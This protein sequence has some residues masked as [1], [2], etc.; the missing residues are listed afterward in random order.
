MIS[1]F[2]TKDEAYWSQLASS[3]VDKIID[4]EYQLLEI[5]GHGAYGCLFLGQSLKDN[6][7]VAVKILA[8]SAELQPLQQLE[9]DIQSELKHPHL[10]AL[11]RFIQDQDYL[12]MI[13]ELCDQGD[14]FDF[15]IKDQ[16]INFVREEGLVK[17]WFHQILDAVEHMHSQGIYHRD[18]K[19]E[20]ILLK[21]QDEDEDELYCKVAD[22]GLA[23]RE[24]YSMEF[25]CG[26]T[27]YLAPEHFDD[28]TDLVPYDAAASDAWSLGILLLAILF[29]R[30][31]WQE[32]SHMDPAYHQFTRNPAMLKDDLFPE[33]SLATL[34]W[35][36]SALTP[37][38]SDR[39][40]VSVLKEQFLA[41]DH[42]YITEQDHHQHTLVD[43]SIP[44]GPKQ[45]NMNSF[46]SAF[47]SGGMSWSDMVEEEEETSQPTKIF[48]LDHPNTIHEDTDIFVHSGE[49]WWL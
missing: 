39:P 33:L 29:G 9:M 45:S 32:A 22:F 5:L 6:S 47:F 2:T 36:Q 35:L 46:D 37:S 42:I 43:L 27:S 48:E 23:T 8:K 7:Y 21:Q 1:S 34:R 3:F 30:T 25:G 12:Y 15:V 40:S 13:M 10:L 11:H 19:L 24:R 49:S 44:T 38:G 20:N 28:G 18:L 16:E 31:P 26:S 17:T 14:L 41:I 4:K